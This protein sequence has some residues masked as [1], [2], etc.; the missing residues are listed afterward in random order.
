MDSQGIASV[1][2]LATTIPTILGC[3]G[4]VWL[5]HNSAWAAW[6]DRHKTETQWFI[7][8]VAVGFIGAAFDNI[9]WGVAWT[10]HYYQHEYTQAIFDGGVYS[11][12]VFRQLAT[13]FAAFCHIRA[14]VETDSRQ[15]RVWILVPWALALFAAIFLFVTR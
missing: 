8:G 1:V 2:S 14:A 7:L 5:W 9:Y 4:V 11:N 12:V 13:A 15:F 6:T 10:A 3:I